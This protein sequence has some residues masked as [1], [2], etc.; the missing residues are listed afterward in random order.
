M[1]ASFRKY[2]SILFSYEVFWEES[3]PNCYQVSVSERPISACS[4][5]NR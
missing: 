5:S 1:S 2:Q 4:F 3:L